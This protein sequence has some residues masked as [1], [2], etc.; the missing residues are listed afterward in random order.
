MKPVI[1]GFR[2]LTNVPRQPAT[3]KFYVP[4]PQPFHPLRWSMFFLAL[5]SVLVITNARVEVR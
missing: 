3:E 5:L 1:P 2:E 4:P